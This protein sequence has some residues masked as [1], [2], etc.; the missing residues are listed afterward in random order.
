MLNTEHILTIRAVRLVLKLGESH[1]N[2]AASKS[3]SAGLALEQDAGRALSYSHCRS[4]GIDSCFMRFLFF[5]G[6]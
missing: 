1:W 4:L 5:L 6:S 3:T 2:G